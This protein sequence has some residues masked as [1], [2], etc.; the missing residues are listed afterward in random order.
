LTRNVLPTEVGFERNLERKIKEAILSLQIE[1]RYSKKQILEFYLNHIEFLYN[2]FGVKAAASTFF[3]KDLDELTV[4][5]CAML[6]GMPKSPT[7]YNPFVNPRRALARRNL[8]LRR[9][10][11]LDYISDEEF[12]AAIDEPLAPR[13]GY[14]APSLYPYFLDALEKDL[15][16]RY[17][18]GELFLK[19]GGFRITATVDSRMQ[20]I[21]ET[22]LREGLVEV[23]RQWQAA[24]LARH[25][26]E[27]KDWDGVL[28]P[29][30]T[31]LMR[32]V[33]VEADRVRVRLEDYYEGEVTLPAELPYYEPANILKEGAWLDVRVDRI[34][35]AGWFVGRLAD[36]RPVQG[37]IVVLD[38][39][40]GEALALVGGSNF[41]ASPGG[42]WNLAIQGGRQPGSCLKPFFYAAA[43]QRAGFGPN[44]VIY[45]EPIEF[46]PLDKPYRPVNYEKSFTMAPMTLCEAL[47]HSRNIVTIR[48][49]EALGVKRALETVRE[50]DF[51]HEESRWKLPPEISTCLGTIDSTPLEIA[52]AYQAL[53][54]DGVGVRPELLRTMLGKDGRVAF[55]V[56]HWEE[57]IIDPIAACQ[58][59]YMM[60]RVVLEGT[61]Q[62]AIGS[63]FPSPPHP[64]ICGKTGTTNDNRDAWFA[65][66]TPDLA[67]VVHVGFD[68]PRPL[69]P[70]LT[71]GRVA[72]PIWAAAFREILKTRDRW[73]MEFDLPA[74]V[75]PTDVCRETGK[76]AS[77]VC[78]RRNHAIFPDM[79]LRAD[80]IPPRCNDVP[81]SPLIAP[82]DARFARAAIGAQ[83][84]GIARFPSPLNGEPP[85]MGDPEDSMTP[86]RF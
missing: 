8:V 64:P 66:F 43:M 76:Q 75:V 5:E 33:A 9:M 53:A 73:T 67:M 54:N 21:C 61:G 59:V 22:S 29:G 70:R 35:R 13:R 50:F 57:P 83:T 37:A 4:A 80:Q 45:D 60:R 10:A 25:Y 79:P 68:P 15:K 55:P 38:V 3:S 41:Y 81:L 2:A 12:K 31:Y 85:S 72:G 74:G 63:K 52:A 51:S 48:L 23:E 40:T 30:S 58:T 71:G 34:E 7:A 24:K 39:H 1:R 27:T 16:R 14:G 32:I 47:E 6:A 65:G 77:D 26:A 46:G 44:S 11:E 82:V 86:L 17:G 56:R 84:L 18:L 28:R 19:Q 20:A 69:G 36:T 42:S 62:S 49:F 78:R